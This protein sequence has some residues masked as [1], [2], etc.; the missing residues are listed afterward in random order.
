[1]VSVLIVC[2]RIM[3]TVPQTF[4]RMHLAPIAEVTGECLDKEGVSSLQVI[5]GHHSA[6]LILGSLHLEPSAV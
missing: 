5:P 6:T 1:M 4:A 3:S 2:K